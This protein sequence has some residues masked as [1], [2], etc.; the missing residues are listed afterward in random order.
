M[1]TETVGNAPGRYFHSVRAV[2]LV[3]HNRYRVIGGEERAVAE[4]LWLVR[5]RLGEE[6]ELLERPAT[7]SAGRAA[8]G[9]LRGGLDA[10]EVAAAV[11]RTGARVVHAHNL[12]PTLGWRALAAAQRAGARTVLH[13]HNYRLVCA[14][15][16]CFTD[17]AD[18]T[19]CHGRDTRPGVR[20]ACRGA[21]AE[22]VVYAAGL[23]AQQRRIIAHADHVVV[24]S[25]FA[26]D[27][28]LELG[29]PIDPAR[30]AVIGHVVRD[31]A[32]APRFDPA[33]P[34]LVAGRLAAEK[35][36]EVAI[37]ACRAAGRPLVVA[38]DG[39][40]RDVLEGAAAGADVRFT[41]RV[42]A[43]ELDQL[44]AA[45]SVAIVP[46]RS[47][48]TFGLAAAE[49]MAAGLPVVA[50]RIGALPELIG[51]AGVLVAPGDAAALAA[52][53][54]RVA[55]DAALRGLR[56]VREACDPERAAAALAAVYAG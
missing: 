23:A 33:G 50:S 43:A 6:A 24:P 25:S 36:I 5:E 54:A 29:A 44:R 55:P 11:R 19:R 13:L 21:H 3:L 47:A 26:R 56:R 12:H 16:T 34:A 42:D 10:D 48:E 2:I 31:V 15:G 45:A 30:V 4:L 7:T 18:C 52:G 51:D 27:R 46:S 28:L 53:L 14:V 41:G 9:L 22:A 20:H 17:G 35:G 40:L 1:T 39:P 38:G 8:L 49:A 32:D 37:A